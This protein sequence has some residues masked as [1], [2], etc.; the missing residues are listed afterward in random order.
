MGFQIMEQLDL[1]HHQQDCRC[2]IHFS[3][4]LTYE[5]YKSLLAKRTHLRHDL[6]TNQGVWS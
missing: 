6:K 3:E 5:C 1:I 4:K 2:P